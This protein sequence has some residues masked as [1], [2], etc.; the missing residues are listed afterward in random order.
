MANNGIDDEQRYS[1]PWGLPESVLA[2]GKVITD[3]VHGDIHLSKLR[4]LRRLP[5]KNVVLK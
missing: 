1:S 2:P 5:P 3:P 4:P